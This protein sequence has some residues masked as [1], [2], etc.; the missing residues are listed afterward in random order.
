MSSN[1]QDKNTIVFFI[2]KKQ[3]KTELLEIT[4]KEILI[5]FANEDP[6]ETT[7]V[8]K[9]GNDLTKYEDDNQTIALENGMHFVVFHD[10]PTTV[11][12]YG[13]DQLVNELKELG[14][15]PELVNSQNQLYVVIREYVVQLGK[16]TGSIIDLGIPA[17]PNFP[18]SVGSSIHIRA[19]PQLYEKEDSIAN[20]RNIIDSDLGGEWRYWSKNF[21]WNQQKQTARRLMAQIA[22]VFK[23]A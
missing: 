17:T 21:N 19:K 20:V 13:P 6:V 22:G 4:A 12:S 3:F 14:Y 11:S 23:D 5:V 18:Q 8:L 1:K 15:E 10:G 7:L 9:I 2:D 16:F